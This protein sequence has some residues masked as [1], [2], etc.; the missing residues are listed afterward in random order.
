MQGRQDQVQFDR[1]FLPTV[2]RLAQVENHRLANP[3]CRKFEA[4]VLSAALREFPVAL[5][6][7][8]LRLDSVVD[9]NEMHHRQDF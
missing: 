9:Q 6:A 5:V 3:D 1:P 7:L 2:V 4:L 8:L